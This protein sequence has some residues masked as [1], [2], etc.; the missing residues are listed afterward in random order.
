MFE[1][2]MRYTRDEIHN[3]LGGSK[4]S[5]LPTKDGYVT[6]VCLSKDMNPDAPDII[7]SGS[8]P[9]VQKSANWLV[10][11]NTLLPVFV[12]ESPN[13]WI[14]KGEFQVKK[15]VADKAEIKKNYR[16]AGRTNVQ[17]VIELEEC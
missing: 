9:M 4:Q 13:N 17:M 10:S 8:G 16:L 14:Y 11:Q 1:V 5:Y 12:K 2:G 3:Q 15:Y 6:C 7:L